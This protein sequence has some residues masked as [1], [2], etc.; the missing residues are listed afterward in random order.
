MEVYMC[1][2][3]FHHPMKVE[4]IYLTNTTHP[5]STIASAITLG[6]TVFVRMPTF[7]TLPALVLPRM[8]PPPALW[9]LDV[10][11]REG[12]MVA[13]LRVLVKAVAGNVAV[14]CGVE[15]WSASSL[16]KTRANAGAGTLMLQVLSVLH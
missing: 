8:L 12:S 9:P 3:V 15:S 13:V 14:C 1:P 11:R 6:T 5:P 7:F 16:K 4:G 10:A 2:R